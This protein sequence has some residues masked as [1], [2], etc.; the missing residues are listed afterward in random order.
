MY[1]TFQEKFKDIDVK[2]MSSLKSNEHNF[3]YLINIIG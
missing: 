1:Q 3:I 2:D